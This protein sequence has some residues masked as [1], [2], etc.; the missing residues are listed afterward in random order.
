M[1]IICPAF[2]KSE[3]DYTLEIILKEWLGIDYFL[4]TGLTSNIEIS[5]EEKSLILT[6]LFFMTAHKKWLL[7][8]SLPKLPLESYYLKN[9]PRRIL[10]IIPRGHNY[11]PVLYGNP[12]IRIYTNKIKCSIDII[13][14]IFFMLSRYEEAVLPERDEHDRF[15]A[16]VSVAYRAGFLERP[17]VN[18]YVELLWGLM[19]YLWPNL[20]RKPRCFRTL[21]SHDVDAPFDDAFRSLYWATRRAFGDI[22]KRKDLKKTWQNFKRWCSVRHSNLKLDRNNTFDFIALESEKRSL[23]SSFYFLPEGSQEQVIRYNVSHPIIRDL[24]VRLDHRG[25]EIG[26]HASYDSYLDSRRVKYEANILRKTLCECGI[27]Q[28]IRGVRQHYLR[29][30]ISETLR[31]LEY[32]GLVYDSSLGFADKPGFRCGTC[33]EY[34]IY[35]VIKRLPLRLIERPLVVMECTVIAKGYMGLGFT[36]DAFAVFKKLKDTCRYYNG[37]FTLLWHNTELVTQ[38][39]KEFY[40][41]VLNA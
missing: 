5:Q 20:I 19:K 6:P 21:L 33:W 17:I 34:P 36:S 25:H 12:D 30:R 1:L 28:K 37:D 16:A 7:P 23:I 27:K 8:E 38:E 2:C 22:I 35:D 41:A 3:I 40:I 14:S 11:L 4:Q 10:N 29:V 24:L 39:Q 26:L 18:E 13:G 32:A 15:P 31:N 9:L